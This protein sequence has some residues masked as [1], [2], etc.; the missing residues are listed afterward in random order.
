MV[1]GYLGSLGVALGMATR[2]Q[3]G[4]V[5][6]GAFLVPWSNREAFARALAIPL[7]SI[8][9]V[10]LSWYYARDYLPSFSNWLLYFVY[11]GLY[12]IFAVTCHRLVLLDTRSVAARPHWSW[13]ETKFLAWVIVI[14][15]IFAVALPVLATPMTNILMWTGLGVHDDRFQ[16]SIQCGQ[17]LALYIV[18]R[19]F[20][21]FP[22]T[23]IDR[24]VNFK[25]AWRRSKNNGWRLVIIVG[26]LPWV[27]SNLVWLLYREN[28][29]I[30]EDI[31]I[32]FLGSAI[33]AF[34]VAALSLSYRELT[35][36]DAMDRG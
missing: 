6:L 15:L 24:R 30:L 29:G 17:I 22:A 16:W 33:V 28:E 13:R 8:V 19:L 3:V 23:A 14:G 25:W 10:N 27:L 34:E 26:A 12:V 32:T 21:V 2:L 20:L 35:K 7:L 4:K 1:A 18:S 11:C 5:L 31:V 36:E 9:A